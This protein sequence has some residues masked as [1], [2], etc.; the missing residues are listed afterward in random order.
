VLKG[1][2]DYYYLM[3]QRVATVVSKCWQHCSKYA[4]RLS[5][6]IFL[7][8]LA[9]KM[10]AQRLVET[11]VA[12]YPV[13]QQNL[14]EIFSN[15]ALRTSDL[16]TFH[17]HITSVLVHSTLVITFAVVTASFRLATS[18]SITALN[19]IICWCLV[20]FADQTA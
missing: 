19:V 4:V 20:G 8:S 2:F 1:H 5:F 7:V 10:K 11:S 15:A 17:V 9:L 6:Q 13:V 14:P 12:V 16:P 3:A 18:K